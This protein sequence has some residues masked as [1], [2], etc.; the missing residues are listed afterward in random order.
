M[1]A[2]IR[3]GLPLV[4]GAL[5]AAARELGAAV[6]VSANALARY[7]YT[8]QPGR[9]AVLGADGYRAFAGFR[10]DAPDLDGLDVAL[11]SA[12]FVAWVHYGA[13]PWTVDDYVQLATSR[14]WAW[15]AQMDACCEAEIAG[16]RDTVRI[17]QAET[18]RLLGECQRAA[19]RLGIP[20]PVPVLQGRTPADYAWHAEQIGSDLDD[21]DLVGVGSMCRRQT[22]GP[23]GLIAVVEE[24]DRI[25]PGRVK[26]HVFGVK[27]EGLAVLAAHPRLASV[28]SMAW[29]VAARA[30]ARTGRT[31]NIRAASMRRWYGAQLAA[32]GRRS[33]MQTGL[34]GAGAPVGISEAGAEWA[35]LL[36][37]GECAAVSAMCYADREACW[38]AA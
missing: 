19:K 33:G 21:V 32:V 7:R 17:R 22:Y 18:I 13:F 3:L 11:D 6:L 8:D 10:L 12:G 34:F 9:R 30:E 23:E 15:W 24:L 38:G 5:P 16:N 37:A 2:L 27:S 1:G 25:L 14:R 20:A 31:M 35:D 29:D 4:G 28:D 36:A 26:L